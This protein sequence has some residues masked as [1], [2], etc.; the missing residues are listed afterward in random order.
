ML[1][2]FWQTWG[3]T[4]QEFSC[5]KCR[6]DA[7]GAVAHKF[8][9]NISFTAILFSN[10]SSNYISILPSLYLVQAIGKISMFTAKKCHILTKCDKFDKRW[11]IRRWAGESVPTGSIDRNFVRLVPAVRY[12]IFLPHFLPETSTVVNLINCCFPKHNILCS[13][14]GERREQRWSSS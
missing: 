1:S 13:S 4:C 7:A 2:E 3:N 8:G 12:W 5:K 9:W 14:S 10:L 11:N 6:T